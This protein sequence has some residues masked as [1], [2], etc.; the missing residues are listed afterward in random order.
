MALFPALFGGAKIMIM[1]P[2][3]GKLCEQRPFRDLKFSLHAKPLTI[4][5]LHNDVVSAI[6]PFYSAQK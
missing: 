2:L 6:L 4:T 1:P 5:Y 3:S